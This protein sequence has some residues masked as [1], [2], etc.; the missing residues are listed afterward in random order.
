MSNRFCRQLVVAAVALGAAIAAAGAEPKL[1]HE[2]E[3]SL[4]EDR[5]GVSVAWLGDADGD[6]AADFLVGARYADV[7]AAI[8]AGSVFVYSGKDGRLL[9]RLD[10]EGAGDWFGV[11]VAG[12]GDVDGD[13]RADF[14]VGAQ[15]G[16]ASSGAQTGT[17]YV[18]SGA[19]GALLYKLAGETSGGRFGVSVAGGQDIDGDGVPDILV[20]AYAEDAAYLYSG[21]TGALI[22]RLAGSPATWYGF[23]VALL[24]DLDK[25]GV[26]ELAISAP[27]KGAGEV[28]VLSGRTRAPIYV[29]AGEQPGDWFGFA[30]ARGGDLDKDGTEELLV[31]SREASPAGRTNAGSVYVYSGKTGGLLKRLDGTSARDR[32]GTSVDRAG[33]VNRDGVADFVVGARFALNA[34]G[35]STGAAYV[36][37]GGSFSLL[38]KIDGEG[39]DDWFAA[40]VSW[41]GDSNGDGYDEILIGA[42]GASPGGVS[43]AGKAYAYGLAHHDISVTALS[44][45]RSARVGEQASFT[46]SVFNRGEAGSMSLALLVN[47]VA[48]LVSA[49]SMDFLATS[50][51]VLNYT[52]RSEDFVGG[53]S[54]V[55]VRAS[56]DGQTDNYAADNLK[57]AA[58]RKAI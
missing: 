10:G 31:G 42:A 58:V 34:A 37:S 25:D 6:G 38:A 32:F 46:A 36:Y 13:G 33:D 18:F 5:L 12:I 2:F 22:A 11:A 29:L 53:T 27:R 49:Q 56:I 45:P 15:F 44:A 35:V 47:G 3:G 48:R 8:D 39:Q 26:G 20:G 4:V 43:R 50:N 54:T 28:T 40:S 7:G 51:P 24:A 23:A 14:I 57:C 30:V 9:Y 52:F 17:A 16:R 1:F 19:S 21:A 55:C 41:A